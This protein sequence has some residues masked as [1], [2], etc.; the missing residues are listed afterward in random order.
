MTPVPLIELQRRLAEAGR[1]RMGEKTAKA[2]KYLDT[3]RLTSPTKEL[4]EQAA[5]LYGGTVKPWTAPTGEQWE[6]VTAATDLPVLIMPAY[7]LN[8]QY[9]LWEGP[10]KCS[11]RCDGETEF[12][13]DASCI[14]NAEGND[15]CDLHTRLTVVLPEL[16]TMLGWR[17][18]SKGMNAATELDTSLELIRGISRGAP[19]VPA[20]LRIVERKGQKDGKATRYV[21]PVIDPAISFAELTADATPALPAYTPAERRPGLGVGDALDVTARQIEGARTSRSAEPIG[22]AG[23]VIDAEP[24]PVPDEAPQ[25]EIDVAAEKEAEL[26]EIVD[27]LGAGEDTRKAC[28]KNRKKWADDRSSYLDWLERCIAAAKKNLENAEPGE[29]QFAKRAAEAQARKAGKEQEGKQE[30]LV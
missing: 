29:S 27:K 18:E 10:S 5:G 24:I 23:E 20:R 28:E 22:P 6:V 15:R 25:P 2:M 1:I 9:E 19:F 14:C 11:R 7:S 26:F 8:R 3:W 30:S 13:S 16:S 12:K 4:I 17:L 21:V